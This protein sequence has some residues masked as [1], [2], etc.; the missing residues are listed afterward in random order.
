[1]SNDL[2]QVTNDFKISK[3]KFEK[4]GVLKILQDGYGFLRSKDFNYLKSGKDIYV[5]QHLIKKY[6][7]KTGDI[8][9]GEIKNNDNNN[10]V[11]NTINKINLKDPINNLKRIPFKLSTPIFPFKKFDLSTN[12]ESLSTRI[13]DMISPIGMGQRGL[14]V[15]QPKTGKTILLKEISKII[16]KNHPNVYIIILLIDERPEEVTDIKRSVPSN[17]EVISSTFDEP[18]EKHVRISEMVIEKS[19]RLV[20]SGH[21]VLI[22]LDSITRLSRAYNTIEP[23]SGRVLSGGVE[24]TALQKPKKFFGSARQIENGGSLTI[25]STALI[26]TGSR[27]DEVIFEEFKGTG[28]MELHLD[29]NLSNRRIYPSINIILSGT[30]RE[31]LLIN[32]KQLEKIWILRNRISDMTPIESIVYLRDKM[33]YMSNEEFLNSF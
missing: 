26:D 9:N 10:L 1:M 20:E 16:S 21:D 25:I 12:S 33:K 13:I 30:R 28:N 19:K 2:L 32:K 3:E 7:L 6:G 5:S 18:P 8:I 22:L 11:L 23:Y 4:S 27:M 31:D 17:V 29:R 14:I 15:S 24:S